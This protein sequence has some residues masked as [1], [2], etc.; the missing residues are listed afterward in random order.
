MQAVENTITGNSNVK[1]LETMFQLLY[2]RLTAPRRDEALFKAFVDKQ[3]TQIQFLTQNPQIG[4]FDTTLSVMYKNHPLAPVPFP[5]AKD[6]D[7]LNMDRALEIYKNEFTNADGYHFF[8]VGNVDPATAVPLL[9]T[10]LGSIPAAN[11]QPEIKDNGVRPV[12]GIVSVKK[13]TEKQS[14]IVAS[15]NGEAPYSDDFKLKAEA[16]AEVLNIKVIEEMREKLGSIYTGGYYANVTK[17]PY[18]HYTVGMQLPC[19]PEN[20]DK[21]LAAANEE[22]RNL[23]E[24]GPEQKDVEKVKNQWKETHR[25]EIQENK[26]WTEAL[27]DVLFWGNDKANILNYDQRVDRLTPADIQQTAKQMFTGKNEFISVLYPE[28]FKADKPRSS[29]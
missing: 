1:D 29:N 28:N 15:Y 27:A 7:A 6:F 23:K 21:L 25:T 13:G 17:F 10:Y 8:L 14:F 16:V 9:E 22:I 11:R 12:P 19:G 26:Y 5:K 18:P 20:V 2:L 3:K 24:K 4:F